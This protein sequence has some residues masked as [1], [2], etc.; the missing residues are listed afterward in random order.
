M[1]FPV[2]FFKSYIKIWTSNWILKY[3]GKSKSN[4]PQCLSGIEE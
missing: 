4:Y 1:N 2:K 3:T